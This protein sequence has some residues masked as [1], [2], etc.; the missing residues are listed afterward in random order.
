MGRPNGSSSTPGRGGRPRPARRLRAR[1]RRGGRRPRPARRR[2]APP[3]RAR[4]SAGTAAPSAGHAARCPAVV[5]KSGRTVTPDRF[6]DGQR[7]RRDRDGPGGHDRR[8]CRSAAAWWSRTPAF[9][10]TSN[11]SAETANTAPGPPVCPPSWCTISGPCSV[12][13]ASSASGSR[14]RESTTEPE[15]VETAITDVPS[16]TSARARPAPAASKPSSAAVRPS[17][18]PPNATAAAAATPTTRRS[19][20]SAHQLVRSQVDGLQLGEVFEARHL[21]PP[22]A[23]AARLGPR[24]RAR[25]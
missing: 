2:P 5:R 19:P 18:E 1:A 3:P 7:L 15:G 11:T 17:S 8:A 23:P 16:A 4:R 10:P 20:R 22:R 9:D 13:A 25:P 14:P 24:A 21:G 6:E 12:H